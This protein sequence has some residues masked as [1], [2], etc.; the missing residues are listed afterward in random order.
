MCYDTGLAG[1]LGWQKATNV[2]SCILL[3]QWLHRLESGVVKSIVSLRQHGKSTLY[4]PN[5][6]KK[7]P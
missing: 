1:G 2:A 5:F 3:L 6:I 4:V 7:S